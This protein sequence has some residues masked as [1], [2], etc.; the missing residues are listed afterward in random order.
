[1]NLYQYF[2]Y[3]V[4][5]ERMIFLPLILCITLFCLLFLYLYKYKNISIYSSVFLSIYTVFVFWILFFP[6]VTS[7]NSE[8]NFRE[9]IEFMFLYWNLLFRIDNFP[10]Y[11]FL[12]LFL[13]IPFGYYLKKKHSLKKTICISLIIVFGVENVQIIIN[14]LCQYVQYT[15]DL[16]DI[17]FHLISFLLGI[18]ISYI[19][20]HAI[21]ERIKQDD[22]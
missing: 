22:F 15:Y 20:F 10:F 7:W 16:C 8:Y 6:V 21:Y 18:L 11:S 3:D 2:N 4:P 12:H 1:M 19:P 13:F 9:E 14:Y 5:F 17:Q